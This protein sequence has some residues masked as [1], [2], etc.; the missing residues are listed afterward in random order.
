MRKLTKI[1][2][3]CHSWSLGVIRCH[4]FYYSLYHSLSFVVTCCHSL[5]DSLSLDVPLFCLSINDL[6]LQTSNH[7]LNL[8][9]ETNDKKTAYIW[10][11]L[12]KQLRY[13]NSILKNHWTWAWKNSNYLTGLGLTL[14]YNRLG[15]EKHS[16]Y[17]IALDWILWYNGLGLKS[18]RITLLELCWF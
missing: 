11:S 2:T 6:K 3:H 14:W 12:N 18:V 7:N 1:T 4:S 10:F 17:L 8:F 15:L 13:C 5:Y 9:S 16:N